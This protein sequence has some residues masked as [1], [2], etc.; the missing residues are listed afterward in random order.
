MLTLVAVSLILGCGLAVWSGAYWAARQARLA[1]DA[2]AAEQADKRARQLAGAL[3]KFRLLPLV[4]SEYPD[5]HA[6]LSDARPD[7]VARLNG[8]LELLAERT[9]AAAIY[10]IAPNGLTLA[11]NN[12][13]EPGSF[14]GQNFSYRPYFLNA[15]ANGGP[16]CSLWV[17]SPDVQA[18]S[19]RAGSTKALE[20]WASSSSKSISPTWKRNGAARPSTPWSSILA[21]SSSS[22]TTPPGDFAPHAR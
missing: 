8:K 19:S 1:T 2:A 6:V 5:V 20:P 10:V 14:V 22:P 13:N 7:S 18:S 17:R 21:A 15:M 16:N 9:D 3:Q 4:L 12:W 11:A